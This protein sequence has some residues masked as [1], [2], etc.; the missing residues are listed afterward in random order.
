M[1]RPYSKKTTWPSK[2]YIGTPLGLEVEAGQEIPR[3]Q[4]IT[5][6]E[7]WRILKKKTSQVRL[8]YCSHEN[9]EESMS[10]NNKLL[11]IN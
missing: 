11:I 3:D 8:P 10:I 5:V 4:D 2:P 1:G 6:G 7:K 9:Q